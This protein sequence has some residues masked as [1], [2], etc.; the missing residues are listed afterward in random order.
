MQ[1]QAAAGTRR[2]ANERAE[3]G[4][5]GNVRDASRTLGVFFFRC[6][7]KLATCIGRRT[8]PHRY[9]HHHLLFT[10]PG[11]C[12]IFISQLPSLTTESSFYYF[13]VV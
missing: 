5:E 9:Q 4:I 2:G 12:L 6:C 13:I 1:D 11:V 3:K 7:T 8:A 10:P